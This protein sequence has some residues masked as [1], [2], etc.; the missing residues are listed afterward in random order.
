MRPGLQ[1]GSRLLHAK[2]FDPARMRQDRNAK[3]SALQPIWQSRCHGAKS[4]FR[5][6]TLRPLLSQGL[7][8]SVRVLPATVPTCVQWPGRRLLLN[9]VPRV[10]SQRY[11]VTDVLPAFPAL[12]L[13]VAV[14]V[15]LPRAAAEEFQIY[16]IDA[17]L[18]TYFNTPSIYSEIEATPTL[19]VADALIFTLVPIFVPFHGAVIRATGFVVSADVVVVVAVPFETVTLTVAEVV[20]C[21]A[22]S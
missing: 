4:P 18:P 1:H 9:H 20:T 17:A 15:C 7:P 6:V 12:S 19:S 22:A 5:P 16:E 10:G 8:F 13:A 21:P 2:T 3:K 11:T 14:I